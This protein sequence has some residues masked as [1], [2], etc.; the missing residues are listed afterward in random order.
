MSF[1]EVQRKHTHREY[2]MWMAHL[3]EDWY[4]MTLTE[5]YLMQVACE[6]RRVLAKKPRRIKLE[7]F[8]LKWKRKE[9]E[10]TGKSKQKETLAQKSKRIWFNI[11]GIKGNGKNDD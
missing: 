2:Q 1:Q 3:E 9:P 5:Y 11:L 10:Q 8:R 6:V 7:H 4:D